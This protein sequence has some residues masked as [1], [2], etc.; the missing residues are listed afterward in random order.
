MGLEW[1]GPTKSET[2]KAGLFTRSIAA[3]RPKHSTL[4]D[5]IIQPTNRLQAL[6]N[7]EGTGWFLPLVS[8]RTGV[9]VCVNGS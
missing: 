7:C 5:N 6:I 8:Y 4:Y 3:T 9:F 2:Q 1:R